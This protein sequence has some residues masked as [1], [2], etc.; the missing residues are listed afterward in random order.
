[1]QPSDRWTGVLLAFASLSLVIGE[2]KA[3]A[4]KND[5]AKVEQITGTALSRVTLTARAVE[6]LGI[7]TGAVREEQTVRQRMIA[8]EVVELGNLPAFQ[9]PVQGMGAD[10]AMVRAHPMGE[11]DRQTRHRPARIWLLTGGSQTEGPIAQPYVTSTV[12]VLEEAVDAPVMGNLSTELV[13]VSAAATA[14]S[15]EDL[16][17]YVNGGSEHG[18]TP[19]QRV[20]IEITMDGVLRKLVPESAIIFDPQ[21]DT[22]VYTNPEPLVF[23]RHQVSLQYIDQEMAIL[24]EGPPAGTLVVTV[25]APLLLGT[26]FKVGH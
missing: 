1:M 10:I 2:L 8:G 19:Q 15:M 25:G 17:F 23:V 12:E 6:R 21:G 18:L 7:T 5:P 9:E 24:S 26:E 11:V 20:F 22:W 16:F 14:S 3:A 13:Q 4:V